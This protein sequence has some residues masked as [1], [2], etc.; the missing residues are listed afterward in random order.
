MATAPEILAVV[1]NHR[2]PDL[3]AACVRSLQADLSADVRVVIVDNASG[4]GSVEYLQSSTAGDDVHIV[5]S[6]VNVGY[7]AGHNLG[8]R[9][10]VEVWGEPSFVWL[11][12]SDI[13]VPAGTTGELVRASRREPS[14]GIWGPTLVCP[15][16][17][18]Q[19][20]GGAR[21]RR[22][23]LSPQLR[24]TPGPFDYI[25]GAAPFLP[26]RAF[27]ELGGFDERFF[28][29]YEEVDLSHRARAAGWQLA[30][31][32]EAAVVHVGGASTGADRGPSAVSE[33]HS[34]LSGL[35]YLALHHKALLP[36]AAVCRLAGKAVL[37][38]AR[39][40]PGDLRHV[41]RA[42]RDFAMRRPGRA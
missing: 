27:D 41:L 13:T 23:M 38:T 18:I 33:Y 6:P 3:T 1:V 24:T 19:C 31:C 26:W 29:Y 4:D 7:G 12:N 35:R 34:S 28:L 5:A 32:P 9:S 39:G 15:D 2:R 16:G 42:Y 21:L 17:A 30:W 36:V 22:W 10:G 20:A 8:V 25:H 14:V 37:L 11:L 40:H